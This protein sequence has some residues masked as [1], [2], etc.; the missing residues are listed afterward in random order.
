LA[1][2]FAWQR[3]FGG[4]P[5]ATTSLTTMQM[6]DHSFRWTQLGW[7]SNQF[8][9]Q[10]DLGSATFQIGPQISSGLFL[11]P[12][13]SLVKLQLGLTPQAAFSFFTSTQGNLD[14]PYCRPSAGAF[15]VHDVAYA[16]DGS[17]TRL[18]ADYSGRCTLGWM[19]YVE[20]G[21]RYGSSI[22]ASVD[23]TFA[24]VGPPSRIVNEGQPLVLDGSLSWNPSSKLT[25]LTWT[26][27]SGPA[28]DLSSCQ[29][30]VC[31]TYTPLVAKGGAQAVF[32][33]TATSESGQTATAD[34]GIQVQSWQDTQSRADIW[35]AG[36]V[37]SGS[38]LHM[39]E[40]DGQ[41]EVPVKDGTEAIYA[42]Q[43]ADRIEWRF[44]PN[45]NSGGDVVVEP[46]FVLSNTMGTALTPGVYSGALKAGFTAGSGP[47]ADFSFNGHG[48]NSPSWTALLATLDRN[49]SDLTVV[50]QG[51]VTFA[52]RCMEGGG[53][54]AS[55]GR[56]WIR[57]TPV[58]PPVVR[59]SSPS[60]ATAGQAFLVQDAGSLT[61]AA[62]IWQASC[63]QIFGAA[64]ASLL[65]T[66]DG[67]CHVTPD[68]STPN[69]SKLVIA[70]EVIDQ[71]GQA[72]VALTEVTVTGGPAATVGMA[73][74]KRAMAS[75]T[76]AFGLR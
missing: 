65:F 61:P 75:V 51:A 68:S 14:S 74:K 9:A 3:N 39:S 29:L 6:F 70:Y 45:G 4:N 15:F 44:Y 46:Q 63:R 8:D 10:T 42:D 11:S 17:L 67:S 62:P 55:Y 31:N 50:N 41:F 1:S 37:S 57:Y 38:E 12:P 28:F 66:S 21:I 69:G 53:G 13:T 25:S 32:R 16:A 20:G 26:Q 54:D 5:V 27:L 24:V 72:G 59:I 19:S 52:V 18:A 23:R 60:V 22:S 73:V 48:C 56:L 47:A 36:Y 76:K 64:S 2:N 40:T 35:G 58:S 33:L 43:T 71:L 34:L 49:P 30:G 7:W